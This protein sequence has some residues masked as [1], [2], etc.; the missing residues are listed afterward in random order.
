MNALECWCQVL[1]CISSILCFIRMH[2]KRVT[3]SWQWRSMD[4]W[5]SDGPSLLPWCR[6]CELFEL[7]NDYLFRPTAHCVAVVVPVPLLHDLRGLWLS[8]YTNA[9]SRYYRPCQQLPGNTY[10]TYPRRIQIFGFF[11]PTRLIW[12][13][14]K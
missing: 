12:E 1:F 5:E 8:S 6:V 2:L 3:G 11:C 13:W 14:D 7:L 9:T 4:N 10:I